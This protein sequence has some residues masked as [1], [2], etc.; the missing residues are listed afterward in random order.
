MVQERNLMGVGGGGLGEGRGAVRPLRP[1]PQSISPPKSSSS[2]GRPPG[3]TTP[4]GW[5]RPSGSSAPRRSSSGWGAR[6]WPPRGCGFSPPPRT[7]PWW[8]SWKWWATCPPS[9]RPCEAIG[10][11]LKTARPDL[12]ILVDFPD[13]NFW[14]ARM[15]K[16]YRVPVHVLHQPPG[17]GLAHLPGAHPGPPHRP[18]GGHLPL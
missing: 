14:V 15:A 13:F 8:A 11:V 9:G 6:P 3:M 12:A 2:P 4:P 10:R 17:L 18:P 1:F 7:W 5:W 16:Y